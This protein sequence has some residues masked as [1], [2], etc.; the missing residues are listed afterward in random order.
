MKASDVLKLIGRPVA[1]YK[2]LSR[3]LGGA[4]AAILFS[5]FFYWCDKT[6]NPLGFINSWKSFAKKQV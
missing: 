3:P 2:D 5:Q 4:T 1:Y 6:D